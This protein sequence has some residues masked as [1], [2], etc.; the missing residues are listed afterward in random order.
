MLM[1]EDLTPVSAHQLENSSPN[2]YI[3]TTCILKLT[4]SHALNVELKE[5]TTENSYPVEN[6]QEDNEECQAYSI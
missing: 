4:H 2:T 3:T 6:G 5:Q 1:R